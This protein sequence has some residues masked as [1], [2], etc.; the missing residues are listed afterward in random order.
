ALAGDALLVSATLSDDHI[1][2]TATANQ[3]FL[4]KLGDTFELFLQAEG[5]PD[6][7]EFQFSPEGHCLQLHYPH[8]T[9]DRTRGLDD[10]LRPTLIGEHAVQIET[11]A[12][13]W[14]LSIRLPLARLLPPAVPP[15]RVW[16]F[17]ACRYDY[18]ADGTFTLSATTPLSRPDFHRVAEWTQIKLPLAAMNGW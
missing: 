9:A 6:Y 7:H 15:P 8:R 5:R 13:R 17:N 12:R 3:Q 4:W 2:T 14:R 16:A 1:T 18:H 10:Y 11:S